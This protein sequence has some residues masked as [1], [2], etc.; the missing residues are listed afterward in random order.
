MLD[1]NEELVDLD[2]PD[3]WSEG[4]EE[5]EQP[6]QPEERD[7]PAQLAERPGRKFGV[8]PIDPKTGKAFI[9]RTILVPPALWELAQQIAP[10][11]EKTGAAG[12]VRHALALYI[13]DEAQRDPRVMKLV[14]HHKLD[15]RL[16]L[17][18]DE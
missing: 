12:L 10:L 7:A 8:W 6:E 1:R 4:G 14:V 16:G 3:D 11:Q 9:P 18:E 13:I 2:G 15:R 5:P 17:E